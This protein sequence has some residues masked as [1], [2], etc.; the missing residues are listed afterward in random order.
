MT[1]VCFH[2]LMLRKKWCYLLSVMPFRYQFQWKLV[3]A[4]AYWKKLPMI[5]VSSG[6]D[7]VI[8]YMELPANCRYGKA[9]AEVNFPWLTDPLL[10]KWISIL[11]YWIS[12]GTILC[13]RLKNEKLSTSIV[14]VNSILNIAFTG[15]RSSISNAWDESFLIGVISAFESPAIR[16]P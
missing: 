16:R 10:F 8:M 13:A 1:K 3:V 7:P 5:K 9:K 12:G 4:S 6:L 2:L 15:L 11:V 14:S